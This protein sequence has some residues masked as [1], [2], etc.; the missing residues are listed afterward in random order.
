VLYYNGLPID[1][2]SITDSGLIAGTGLFN[3]GLGGLSDGQ[4]A[5]LLDASALLVPEPIAVPILSLAAAYVGF[6]RRGTH[7]SENS[8]QPCS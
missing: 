4:R 8:N 5:Y 7:R 6:R 3:D 1:A 2:R